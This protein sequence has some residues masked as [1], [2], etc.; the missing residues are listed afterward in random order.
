MM[1]PL[2]KYTLFFP[3][4]FLLGCASEPKNTINESGGI[5]T[6]VNNENP[7]ASPVETKSWVL[8]APNEK[9]CQADPPPIVLGNSFD[10]KLQNA[11][12]I[13]DELSKLPWKSVYA[14]LSPREHQWGTIELCV[15][16]ASLGKH[17]FDRH[18]NLKFDIEHTPV[19]GIGDISAEGGR[20]L[21]RHISHQTGIEADI[22]YLRKNSP[23]VKLPTG[24]RSQ[25]NGN[26]FPEKIIGKAKRWNSNFDVKENFAA[27]AFLQK[28]F[29]LWI[30][31][32][33][34]MIAQIKKQKTELDTEELNFFLKNSKHVRGHLDHYHMGLRCLATQPNCEEQWEKW[35]R[36][37][38]AGRKWKFQ[39]GR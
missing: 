15:V 32:D 36:G 38:R 28:K 10:G 23:N 26:R 11:M 39:Y 13:Q 24:H 31:L 7:G 14:F 34:N 12:N 27:F 22:F 25:K 29:G 16:L 4:L 19:I 20:R 8:E 9:V 33:R 1:T 35:Q 30:T 2:L 37:R 18:P 21:H 17:M 5:R 6:G 3:L